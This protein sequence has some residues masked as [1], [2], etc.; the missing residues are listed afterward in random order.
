MRY[1]VLLSTKRGANRVDPGKARSG[2]EVINPTPRRLRVFCSTAAITWLPPITVDHRLGL[3][4]PKL[5][6]T[7]QPSQMRLPPS[8]TWNVALVAFGT[9]HSYLTTVP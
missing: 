9:P 4:F 2:S 7:D 6:R 3:V 1:T 8:P 5:R